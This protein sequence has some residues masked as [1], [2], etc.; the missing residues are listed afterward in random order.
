MDNEVLDNEVLDNEVSDNE[1][2]DKKVSDNE[3]FQE[4]IPI[5]QKYYNYKAKEDLKLYFDKDV[6]TFNNVYIS[7]YN[8]NSSSQNPF[9]NFLLTKK[10]AREDLQF[11]E[12]PIFKNF[13][14]TELINY[15]KIFLFGLLKLTEL[16]NFINLL[17]FNGFYIFENNLYLFFDITNCEISVNDTYSNSANRFA[18]IDEIVNHKKVCNFKIEE[19]ITNLF[20][21]NNNLCF[22]VDENDNLYETPI[23]SF[24]GTLKEQM[25][26]KYVFGESAQNKNAILGPYFYFTNFT[27]SFKNQNLGLQENNTNNTNN[28]NKVNDCIIRFALFRGKVKYILNNLNDPIDKSEIKKQRLEDETMDQNF[29]HLTIRITDHDG[30]WSTNFNSVYLGYTELDNGTYLENTPIIVVKEYEQQHS[31]SYHY[32]N[33]KSLEGENNE[34]SIL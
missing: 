3:V 34:Y 32:V 4:Y 27:N 2:S 17:I 13:E 28:K 6:T 14:T 10:N 19:N 5:K 24:I 26:F 29:E 9:L 31:L 25:N 12:V 16:E 20:I 8:V 22:L 23:V 18:L 33:K 11:P 15:S 30:L 7:A 21:S 1:V